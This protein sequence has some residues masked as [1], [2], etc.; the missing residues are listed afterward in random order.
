VI[1]SE[2]ITTLHFVPSMLGAFLEAPAVGG[3]R[4]LRRVICSGEALSA[5]L[6]GR[7]YGL[8]GD[9][10]LHNLYG[11]TE[12]AVDVTYWAC[13]RGVLDR[14]LIGSPIANTQMH[15]VDARGE[16]VGVG[17]W[18]ELCIGGVQVGRG[19]LKRAE[20]TAEKFVPD[21][22]S[23]EAGARL[24]RTGDVCRWLGDG[25]LEY[26]GRLDHQVK[27][28]GFRIE[29]GEIESALLSH[30]SV[31]ECVVL[32][33]EDEPGDKRLVAYLVSEGPDVSRSEWR[34]FLRETLPDYMFPSTFVRL[35]AFPLT[36]SGKINR[37]ALPKPSSEA[38]VDIEANE[39]PRT[40]TETALASIW[41]DLLNVRPIGVRDD[42]FDLG[43][44]SL[45]A[46]RLLAEIN[47][48]MGRARGKRGPAAVADAG[49]DS[50]AR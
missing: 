37:R 31:R 9:V 19:Y 25:T 13:P 50:A 21:P 15:V 46:V 38:P 45:L 11:P 48:R 16:R 5:E 10:E 42:F 6:V 44:H 22:F 43:G 29:L 14:V 8:L 23:V 47:T 33:R 28:R 7:F 20:L 36:P 12:A 49:A 30:P 26:A 24:Y 2:Q 3:C 17:V 1:E 27:L 18:G 35:E 40:S 39:R 41:E 4:S 32:A 34:S